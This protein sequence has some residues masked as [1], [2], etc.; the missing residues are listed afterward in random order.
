MHGD[1][2]QAARTRRY[3]VAARGVAQPGSA[4]RS[5]RSISPVQIWAPRW[6]G[7]GG[8]PRSP[9]AGAPR[10]PRSRRDRRRAARLS[11]GDRSPR[12]RAAAR[13]AGGRSRPRPRAGLLSLAPQSTRHGARTRVAVPTGVVPGQR[14]PGAVRV[15]AEVDLGEQR[16]D[17]AVART[18]RVGCE[19]V[20]EDARLS[21]P[22]RAATAS[23][24]R[25]CGRADPAEEREHA[26]GPSRARAD[27]RGRREHEPTHGP[28]SVDREA[29]PDQPA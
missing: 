20:P 27:P 3:P 16:L 8:T 29:E 4:L 23:A 15:G 28:G 6:A 7:C 18:S 26:L 5:G 19:P 11:A 13:A 25:S 22:L 12:S 9:A 24:A 17:R 2:A 14:A 10:K 21:R 1:R